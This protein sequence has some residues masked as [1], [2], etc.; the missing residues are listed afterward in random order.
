[1]PVELLGREIAVL[2][3][4]EDLRDAVRR[5]PGEMGGEQGAGEPV[6]AARRA[7]PRC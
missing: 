3:L 5:E 1:M 6:A 4:E 7:T 2:D